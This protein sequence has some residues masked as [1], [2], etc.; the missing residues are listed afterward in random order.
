V[1]LDGGTRGGSPGVME[2]CRD[3]GA[4]LVYG[5]HHPTA[6]GNEF[7]VID[8][9]LPRAES[10]DRVLHVQGAYNEK[11][12]STSSP[13]LQEGDLRV[14]HRPLVVA[15]VV[16]H[17]GQGDAILELHG[18]DPDRTKQVFESHLGFLS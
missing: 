1:T 6:T 10:A 4:V 8:P 7:V 12:G 14:G 16:R 13:A 15:H 5:F 11:S 17:G 3:L 9:E 2:L 18:P